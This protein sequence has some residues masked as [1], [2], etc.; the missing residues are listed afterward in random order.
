MVIDGRCTFPDAMTNRT[1]ETKVLLAEQEKEKRVKDQAACSM[2]QM[3]FLPA[4]WTTCW[5]KGDAFI[6]IVDML[7]E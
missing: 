3:L 4:V 1:K 2:K 5:A 7:A 6:K